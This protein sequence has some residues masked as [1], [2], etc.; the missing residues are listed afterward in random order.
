[1]RVSAPE[2]HNEP[3]GATVINDTIEWIE[4]QLQKL[5]AH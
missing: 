1:V 2:T 3:N 5:T 4:R